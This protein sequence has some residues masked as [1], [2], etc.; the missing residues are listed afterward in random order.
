MFMVSFFGIRSAVSG[1]L[2]RAEA[3]EGGEDKGVGLLGGRGVLDGTFDGAETVATAVY[4][5]RDAL[6]I[7]EVDAVGIEDRFSGLAYYVCPQGA[8]AE[9]DVKVRSTCADGFVGGDGT[10]KGAA[11]VKELDEGLNAALVRGEDLATVVDNA[12]EA[13]GY[14]LVTSLQNL[15]IH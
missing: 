8:D 10:R 13:A 4:D 6:A 12:G 3:G 2:F 14:E 7:G 11:A 1:T 15:V 5:V 9:Q